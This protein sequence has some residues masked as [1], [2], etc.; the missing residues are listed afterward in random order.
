[1]QKRGE[2]YVVPLPQ[3]NKISS[4]FTQYLKHPNMSV[5]HIPTMVDVHQIA[6]DVY[7]VDVNACLVEDDYE[8]YNY[9]SNLEE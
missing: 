6:A 1:M 7:L 8:K 9:S 5:V 4:Y 2:E 3:E